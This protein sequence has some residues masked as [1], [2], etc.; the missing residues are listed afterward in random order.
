MVLETE[1]ASGSTSCDAQS[2]GGV[3]AL[4]E[5]VDGETQGKACHHWTGTRDT[6]VSQANDWGTLTRTAAL[7][8]SV[9]LLTFS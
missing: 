1:K 8:F 3:L 4:D 9:C 6:D 7:F 5:D 2:S